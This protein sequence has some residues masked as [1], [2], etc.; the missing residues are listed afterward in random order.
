MSTEI[1]RFAKLRH[2][3]ETANMAMR[4]EI[5]FT[6]D[7]ATSPEARRLA[8][9]SRDAENAVDRCIAPILDRGARDTADLVCLAEVCRFYARLEFAG[10]PSFEMNDIS[11][12]AYLALINGV[13][14]LAPDRASEQMELGA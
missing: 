2:L 12:R 3:I 10:P 5:D 14:A 11:E 1:A 6:G 13:V 8:Q 4:K 7:A 9:R